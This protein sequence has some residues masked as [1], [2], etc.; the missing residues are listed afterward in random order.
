MMTESWS[1]YPQSIVLPSTT[2]EVSESIS[3]SDR[4]MTLFLSEYEIGF[5]SSHLGITL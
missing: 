1:E 4:Y 5:Q 3:Y 2:G